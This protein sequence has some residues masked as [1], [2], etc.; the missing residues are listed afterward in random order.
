MFRQIACYL[1]VVCS[2]AWTNATW[3]YEFTNLGL[4]GGWSDTPIPTV[5]DKSDFTTDIPALRA[6]AA[7]GNA[8]QTWDDVESA[9]RL[10]FAYQPDNGDNY[11]VFDTYPPT[12]DPQGDARYADIVLGGWE[13]AGYFLNLDPVNGDNILAVTWTAQMQSFPKP[14]PFWHSEIFFNDDWTWTDNADLAIGN[15]IDIETVALH[16][17]GHALG[18]DHENDVDSVMASFYGG[19]ERDLFQDDIDA[20]T[21]LYGSSG[22]GGGKG[23]GGGKGGPKRVTSDGIEW[24]LSGATYADAHFAASVPEP[25]TLLLLLVGGVF[26]IVTHVHRHRKRSD[27][28]TV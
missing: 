20:V 22:S 13:D 21:A 16:E 18:L 5:L 14:K 12:L 19:V 10:S 3:G 24:F 17:I 1:V 6:E 4:A 8:F 28:P 27:S 25:S 2:F 15:V 11:D 9:T 7:L 26:T 23:N